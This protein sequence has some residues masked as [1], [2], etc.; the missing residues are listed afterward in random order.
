MCIIFSLL[1]HMLDALVELKKLGAY[2]SDESTAQG[3]VGEDEEGG[4]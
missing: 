2:S 4:E 1:D 3:Q